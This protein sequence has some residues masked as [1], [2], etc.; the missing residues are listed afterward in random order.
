M[1]EPGGWEVERS[2]QNRVD[3][4]VIGTMEDD[5]EKEMEARSAPLE[6]SSS[7]TYKNRLDQLLLSQIQGIVQKPNR[8]LQ[9]A[10][11]AAS[12]FGSQLGK[13]K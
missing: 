9:G 2:E 4:A 13:R 1:G 10:L 7:T 6:Q 5:N 12:G 11:Q 8:Q 3:D